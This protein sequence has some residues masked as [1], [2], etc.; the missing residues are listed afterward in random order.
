MLHYLH[1]CSA[2]H[3]NLEFYHF[4]TIRVKCLTSTFADLLFC[5]YFFVTHF[6]FLFRQTASLLIGE[7]TDVGRVTDLY[8]SPYS[9]KI[10][11]CTPM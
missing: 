6:L 10:S 5:Q 2:L 3:V 8:F 11:S 4:L 1:Q 9:L 7:T